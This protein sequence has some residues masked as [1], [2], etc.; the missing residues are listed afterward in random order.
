[1]CI[2][3]PLT[4]TG[5]SYG[6]TVTRQI[7]VLKFWVRNPIAQHNKRHAA[8]CGVCCIYTSEHYLYRL[9]MRA[10]REVL[11]ILI[12]WRIESSSFFTG[13]LKW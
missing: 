10:V 12:V 4:S 6:V 8:K 9:K 13:V 3:A 1:M 5:L 11:Y 2:F 7:L